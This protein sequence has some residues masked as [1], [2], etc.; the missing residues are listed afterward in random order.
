MTTQLRGTL[1][2]KDA[3]EIERYLEEKANG[4]KTTIAKRLWP[5]CHVG[6]RCTNTQHSTLTAQTSTLQFPTASDQ[7]HQQHLT[8][9]ITSTPLQPQALTTSSSPT[10]DH[11][12]SSTID[13]PALQ[14]PTIPTTPTRLSTPANDASYLSTPKNISKEKTLRVQPLKAG[15]VGWKP[16]NM[17]VAAILA[18][19]LNYWPAGRVKKWFMHIPFFLYRSLK[20]ETPCQNNVQLD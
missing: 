10:L 1:W 2:S 18:T 5:R 11:L 4:G 15:N 7:Q 12:T 16:H 14:F 20:N 13:F 19:S 3:A 8:T 9:H 17:A 6:V